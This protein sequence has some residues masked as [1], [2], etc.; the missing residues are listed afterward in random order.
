MIIV[1]RPYHDCSDEI[2]E[3]DGSDARLVLDMRHDGFGS[4]PRVIFAVILDRLRVEVLCVP[5]VAHERLELGAGR[6]RS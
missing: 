5:R 1:S 3:D 6:H 2:G 4:H